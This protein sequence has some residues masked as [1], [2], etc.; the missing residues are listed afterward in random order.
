MER[1]ILKRHL[2]WRSESDDHLMAGKVE[3]HRSSL[4][5][6]DIDS[7]LERKFYWSD[8]K[9]RDIVRATTVPLD[10]YIIRGSSSLRN[11]HLTTAQ[12]LQK[13]HQTCR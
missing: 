9:S 6:V 2:A 13:R 3:L 10:R 4:L 12:F 8:V 5:V 1:K 7:D 11:T